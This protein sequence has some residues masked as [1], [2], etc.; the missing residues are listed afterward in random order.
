MARTI[1]VITDGPSQ[2]H[3]R[4]YLIQ[5]LLER[6]QAQGV[7]IAV[8]GSGTAF[9][10]ADLAILHVDLSVVPESLR[11]LV[12]KYPKVINGRVLDIRKR[13]FSELLI[14]SA[15]ESV[16]PV[17]VKTNLNYGGKP[18]LLHLVDIRLPSGADRDE[19]RARA[20]WRES[21]R[22]WRTRRVLDAYQ[23]YESPAQVPG[24][25]WRNPRLVVERF[26]PEV[27]DG[28][29]CC[30][31]WLFLGACEVGRMTLSHDPAV[32]LDGR[33]APLDEPV[34]EALRSLRRQLGFDYGKFDYSVVDGHAVI[35]DVNRTPGRR[36]AVH[37]LDTVDRLL[38]GLVEI[39][40]KASSA[41]DLA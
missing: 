24:D 21:R 17:L 14:G 34:P 12:I 18:E 11:E 5:L 38:P 2:F 20:L 19:A 7:R 1:A 29:Y 37:H 31:H 16:G 25:V 3:G 41:A 36:D 22:P 13:R 4:R 39:F 6:L 32:R 26:V 8:V 28:M 15:D 33:P 10:P 35:Y 30:R 40:D 9:V 27:R 23:V